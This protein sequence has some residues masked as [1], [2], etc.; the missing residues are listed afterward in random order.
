MHVQDLIMHVIVP[1]Q[2]LGYM[3]C[4]GECPPIL[5]MQLFCWLLQ[6]Q[7]TLATP[8][9]L[10][11]FG[12]KIWA[13]VAKQQPTNI[14]VCMYMSHLVVILPCVNKHKS[15]LLVLLQPVP[16]TWDEPLVVL[17]DHGCTSWNICQQELVESRYLKQT[18]RTS[19]HHL[20]PRRSSKQS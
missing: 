16:H 8:W 19:I 9:S 14:H 6:A 11:H 4:M 12:F 2:E 1:W 18:K 5:V 10:L 13:L 17:G 15:T 7:P 20:K 3:S